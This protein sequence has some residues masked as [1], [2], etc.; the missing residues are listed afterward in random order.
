LRGVS[1]SRIESVYMNM[2]RRQQAR[3]PRQFDRKN[4]MA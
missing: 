1:L 4:R 2:L 3:L